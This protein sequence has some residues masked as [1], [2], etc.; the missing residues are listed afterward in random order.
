MLAL[1]PGDATTLTVTDFEQV[2]LELGMPG[3]PTSP[4]D[5]A[6]FW[7]R[8]ETE[9]PML[10]KGMLRPLE[11][12]LRAYG[13]AQ[14]DVDWEA[15][16]FDAD[17]TETGWVVAFRDGTD[18][19]AVQRAVDEGVGPFSGAAVDAE[20]RLVESGTTSDPHQSWAADE[21]TF[22]MVGLPANATYVARDCVP[23]E[24]EVSADVD[25][26]GGYSV[27]FEGS[28]VTARLGEGRHD[29]FTADAAGCRHARLRRGVRRRGGRPADR[30]DR[31]RDD[32]PADRRPARPRPPVAVRDLRLRGSAPGG[33]GGPAAAVVVGV[34]RAGGQE[35]VAD[36]GQRASETVVHPSGNS[37]E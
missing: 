30:P 31:L 25:E 24:P 2:R 19:A 22:A 26:L 36:D 6:T 17:D 18:M 8:A 28:L 27:Q 34:Q 35:P 20:Q 1:V 4:A 5:E 11:P 7:Q 21:Q 10:S 14:A 37:P 13:F 16:F 23:P 32:R 9:R 33:D 15:H 12:T 3:E 29:L